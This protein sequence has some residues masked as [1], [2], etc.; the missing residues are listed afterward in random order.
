M[1]SL[2]I[3]RHA[4]SSRKDETLSDHD[5]P[6]NRRGKRD[7]PRLGRLVLEEG[8][9]PDLIVSSTANRARLTV[10]NCA[11]VLAMFL[12]IGRRF[13]CRLA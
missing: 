2:L 4:K 3:L 8:L 11:S 13:P 10:L 9:V 1:K 7:A 6:L 12:R 5:R